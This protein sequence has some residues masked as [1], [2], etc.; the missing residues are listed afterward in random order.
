MLQ[1]S[2]SLVS[3]HPS[4]AALLRGLAAYIFGINLQRNTLTNQ[5]INVSTIGIRKFKG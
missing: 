4:L 2:P 5:E 1:A 3:V